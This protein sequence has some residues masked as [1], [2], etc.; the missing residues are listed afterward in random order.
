MA[1]LAAWPPATPGSKEYKMSVRPAFSNKQTGN[2]VQAPGFPFAS[3]DT[4]VSHTRSLQAHAQT[5]VNIL[6]V[7]I[8]CISYRTSDAV[9]HELAN[10]RR[11]ANVLSSSSPFGQKV[12][13]HRIHD[14]SERYPEQQLWPNT[15]VSI[16][17][18]PESSALR[19]QLSWTKQD[20]QIGK[21]H[22]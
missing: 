2:N 11:K 10:R 13:W 6:V 1:L 5:Y 7:C 22:D 15:L 16:C 17:V 9:F 8:G 20:Y 14:I 18:V 19:A 12:Q 4:S 21:T 3:D